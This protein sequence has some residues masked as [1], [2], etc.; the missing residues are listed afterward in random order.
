MVNQ[1]KLNL[2][3]G[4]GPGHGAPFGGE[5]LLHRRRFDDGGGGP[6]APLAQLTPGTV[7]HRDLY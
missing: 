3:E 7:M 2:G 4:E 5:G 1:A 6:A